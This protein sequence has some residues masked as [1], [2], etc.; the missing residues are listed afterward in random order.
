MRLKYRTNRLVHFKLKFLNK[1]EKL[2]G[3]T[4]IYQKQSMST[5]NYICNSSNLSI[6]IISKVKKVSERGKI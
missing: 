2:E 5:I 1:Y 6:I 4:S 3:N